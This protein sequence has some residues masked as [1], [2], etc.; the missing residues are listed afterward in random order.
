MEEYVKDRNGTQAAMR[1]GYTHNPDSARVIACRLLADTNIQV[2][3]QAE[4]AR[5]S[6]DCRIEAVDI[7]R[8]CADIANAD[9][10]MLQR[11]RQLNCRHCWGVDHA[12]Q[13]ATREYAEAVDLATERGKPFPACSGGF[14][15]KPKG[16][17]NPQCPECAGEG[18]EGVYIA[19]IQTLTGPERRLFAGIKMT[20]NGP[21]VKMRD[22]DAARSIL[23]RY[24]GLLIE[25]KELSGPN[26]GPLGIASFNAD[27]LSDDQLAAILHD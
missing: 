19:D 2:L 5:V 8:D 25:R 22:Q 12:Y 6:A 27:D 18:V 16:D 14:G 10:S 13:W 20:A 21:E 24:A 15:W 26:G 11:V 17:P 3:V 23:A 1:A 7:L 9:P 4:M